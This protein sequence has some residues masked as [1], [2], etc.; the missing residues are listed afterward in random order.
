M[1]KLLMVLFIGLLTVALTGCGG[2]KNE[3]KGTYAS[4]EKVIVLE[5]D[6]YT[7]YVKG[8]PDKPIDVTYYDVIDAD[9]QLNK[10]VVDLKDGED[11]EVFTRENWYKQGNK[12]VMVTEDGSS[13]NG[14]PEDGLKDY[15]PADPEDVE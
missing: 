12:M 13:F 10:M 14:Y 6:K 3:I 8:E 15:K 2:I 9:N 11:G 7:L 4:S 5:K 1:K